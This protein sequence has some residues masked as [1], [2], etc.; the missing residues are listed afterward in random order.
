MSTTF[1]LHD[2]L[3]ILIREQ[4]RMEE[5]EYLFKHALAQEAAYDSILHQ[6]RKDLHLQVARSIEKVFDER[7]HEFYR[8]EEHTSELQS[9]GITSYAVFCL[10]KTMILTI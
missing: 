5:L 4:Q 1:S 9:R 6:K 2:A 8:S 7:L 10:K 3:P